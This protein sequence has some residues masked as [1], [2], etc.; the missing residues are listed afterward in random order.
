MDLHLLQQGLYENIPRSIPD[1]L[2]AKIEKNALR[3]PPIFDFIAQSG[4]IPERD[5]FNTFNMGV[6][7]S[8]TVPREQADMALAILREQ[9]EDAYIMG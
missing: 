2:G 4:N 8:V 7:M 6:G 5:M 1:G 3:T 9:D